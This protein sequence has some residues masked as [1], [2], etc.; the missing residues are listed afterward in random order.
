M[1]YALVLIVLA[2]YRH[3]STVSIGLILAS[4]G[5]F[6]WWLRRQKIA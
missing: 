6:G 1:G 5:L 4:G 2:Q 3:A